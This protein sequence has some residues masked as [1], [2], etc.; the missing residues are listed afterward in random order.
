MIK[1]SLQL[2]NETIKSKGETMLATLKGLKKPT[3]IFL[4]GTLTVSEG[5]KSRT[6][7]LNVQRVK[8]LFQPLAQ[9]IISKQ[10]SLL[11]K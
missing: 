11:L 6:I 10:L 9:T 1:A 3:K 7:G 5:K 2:G 8:R 4:M